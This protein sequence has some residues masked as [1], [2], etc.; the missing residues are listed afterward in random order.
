M[1]PS[2]GCLF[3]VRLGRD[4]RRSTSAAPPGAEKRPCYDG[5]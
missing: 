2:R 5:S 1:N 3:S 4:N